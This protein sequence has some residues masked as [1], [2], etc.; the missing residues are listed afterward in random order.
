MKF[1]RTTVVRSWWRCW[2]LAQFIINCI[3]FLILPEEETPI[4]QIGRMCRVWTFAISSDSC[5]ILMWKMFLQLEALVSQEQWDL[6]FPDGREAAHRILTWDL[7]RVIPRRTVHK[8]HPAFASSCMYELFELKLE[9][10]QQN[11][12]G[13]KQNCTFK[14]KANEASYIT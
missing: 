14:I 6:V 12:I 11:D 3:G 8:R 4:K 13:K 7:S 1:H 9:R 2:Q 10:L 5:E